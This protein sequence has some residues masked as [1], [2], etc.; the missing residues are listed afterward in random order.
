M[1]INDI[2]MKMLDKD[3]A[4]R[5][6]S[7]D[8]VLAAIKA[9]P[10]VAAKRVAVVSEIQNKYKKSSRKIDDKLG[11]AK[12]LVF[13]MA[14]GLLALL[15]Y[16]APDLW[17]RVPTGSELEIPWRTVNP[18]PARTEEQFKKR[19]TLLGLSWVTDAQTS[20]VDQFNVLKKLGDLYFDNQDFPMAYKRY[21]EALCFGRTLLDKKG[22]RTQ[23]GDMALCALRSAFCCLKLGENENAIPHCYEG[24]NWAKQGN[25]NPNDEAFFY[26]IQ[27]V[28]YA[29]LRQ[30]AKAE[31][32]ANVFMA[33]LHKAEFKSEW[34][35]DIGPLVSSIGDFYLAKKERTKALDAY[36]F[37]GKAWNAL[38]D[39]GK[40]NKA[41]LQTRLGCIARDEGKL[42]P[43]ADLLKEAAPV[44]EKNDPIYPKVL[45]FLADTYWK[46][47]DLRDCI[48]ALKIRSEAVKLWKD[49]QTQRPRI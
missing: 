32:N 16:I 1:T 21:R 45:F 47:N 48:E 8:E 40:Y 12:K 10:E 9:A 39:R 41:V 19:E 33:Y 14:F 29:N 15:C 34:S 13:V 49:C 20:P 37:A 24:L 2:V 36:E 25:L 42:V 3:P 28:V 22:I 23:L 11:G 43:A 4:A 7:M 27:A 46:M 31:A 17:T 6:Q 35:Y 5:Y 26:G 38:E 18:R 30:D 44:F